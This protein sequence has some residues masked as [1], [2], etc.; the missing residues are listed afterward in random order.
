MQIHID[1]EQEV[2]LVAKL[3]PSGGPTALSYSIRVWGSLQAYDELCCTLL[4]TV[5]LIQH[6]FLL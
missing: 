2:T 3:L 5:H 4:H 6:A 1:N